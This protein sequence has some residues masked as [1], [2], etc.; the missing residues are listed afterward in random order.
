M[1]RLEIISAA[2]SA[3]LGVGFA[4]FL[5]FITPTTTNLGVNQQNMAWMLSHAAIMASM[6][7]IAL[8]GTIFHVQQHQE[9]GRLLLWF[10][11]IVL[12]VGSLWSNTFAPLFWPSTLL[13]IMSTIASITGER[14]KALPA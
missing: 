12:V 2:I 7:L 13:I 8:L 6:T 11:T 5:F 3:A 14:K 4:F 10:A 9:K 1:K